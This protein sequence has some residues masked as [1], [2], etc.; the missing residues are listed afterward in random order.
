MVQINKTIFF[1]AILIIPV[2]LFSQKKDSL[3]FQSNGILK[4]NEGNYEAAEI[5]FKK[6]LEINAKNSVTH[7][8]L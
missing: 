2:A 5:E 1:L 3:K 4:F 7:Y 8:Y 6:V